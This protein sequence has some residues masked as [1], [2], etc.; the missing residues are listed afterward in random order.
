ML[1]FSAEPP[2]FDMPCRHV[3]RTKNSNAAY[4]RRFTQF[5]GEIIHFLTLPEGT[6]HN[7]H[8]LPFLV[9]VRWLRERNCGRQKQ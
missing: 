9:S 8:H 2:D 6:Y 5:D 7:I 3:M 4:E 1:V